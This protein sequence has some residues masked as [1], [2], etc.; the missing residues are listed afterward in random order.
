[1]SNFTYDSNKIPVTIL[2]GFLGAG[3]TTLL[4]HI[5]TEM[6]GMTFAV[7][8]NEFGEVG[9]DDAIVKRKTDEEIIEMNNGCICCTVRGDLSK[10]IKQIVARK[11]KKFDAIIIETTGL[12]DPAPVAQTFFI[13]E[14]VGSLCQL[15]G[16]I[17]VVDSKHILQH[18]L[19]KKQEGVE[20]ESVEQ[21]AFAD[22]ILLNKTDLVSKEEL[23]NV[24]LEIA[25]INKNVE[26]VEC[27]F[28]KVDPKQLIGIKAFDLQRCLDMEPD[29][30][31]DEEHH[32][33]HSV[34][35]IGF[36]F[37][38]CDLSLGQLQ[39]WIRNLIINHG[40]NLYRYKGVI[41]V[42]GMDNRFVF[43]GV[44]ML[45]GGDFAEPWNEG[46]E[47]ESRFVF[48]GKNLDKKML[49][50][51]FMKCKAS[52]LR[53]KVGDTIYANTGTGYKRGEIIKLWDEGNPYRIK[54]DSGNEVWG[55]VDE[56][57]FV[58]KDVQATTEGQ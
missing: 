9:V 48:I 40:N 56:D 2:T 23:N 16:I 45:F 34:S 39:E 29:F 6:H 57:K 12:A 8:E 10:I 4:N 15:D 19:E 36:K 50:D 20:N 42:K 27:Q 55:P 38:D 49:E 25:K 53:F 33:D 13:D 35:S 22:R 14:T 32:H 11:D 17:T 24:K 52:K 1:M 18:L 21:V 44:H 28:S 7:I 43:Q 58:R 41:S 31:Q 46:E 5:L 51:G 54:L 30:L 47:R 26:M 3:K 37:S